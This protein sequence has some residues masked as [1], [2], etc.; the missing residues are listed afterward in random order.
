MDLL[1]SRYASPYEFMNLYIDQ[2][3]FGEFVAEIF[4][5]DLKRKRKEEEKENDNR[6]WSAYI[7]SMSDKSFDEWKKELKHKE[8]PVSYS[9]TNEQVQKVKEQ[10]KGILKRISPTREW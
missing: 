5:M 9:M 1:Y 4:G 8:K 6:L 10:A 7:S 2:G 3:R